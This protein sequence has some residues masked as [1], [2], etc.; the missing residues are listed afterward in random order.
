MAALA[1][2]RGAG[3]GHR[4]RRSRRL[5][6]GFAATTLAIVHACFAQA[7]FALTV[8]LALFTAREWRNPPRGAPLS[9][10]G[11]LRR[12]SGD[13]DGA[14]LLSNRLRRD[15]APHRRT[16]LDAHLL[17]AGLVAVH[18]ILLLLRIA[19]EH[20]AA[21]ALTRPG[22]LL[23]GLLVGQL[24]LGALSYLAKF[25]ALIP[26]PPGALVLT[27]TTHLII[28]ALMLGTSLVIALRSFRLSQPV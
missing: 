3:F 20:G 6:R 11:R 24:L 7:F 18:V 8:S 16:R 5:A 10:G 23:G 26:L 19:R 21:T 22:Y 1:R 28:G 14:H 17:F 2:R 9:D 12:L 27:T 4:P 25:T 15:V 13:H